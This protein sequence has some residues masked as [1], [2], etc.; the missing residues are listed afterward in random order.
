MSPCKGSRGPG[1]SGGGDL[2]ARQHSYHM[3]IQGP[4]AAHEP[5][6]PTAV[7]PTPNWSQSR[8]SLKAEGVPSAPKPS[9][10]P[11]LRKQPGKS[12]HRLKVSH[13]DQT[14][15]E[16]EPRGQRILVPTVQAGPP[17]PTLGNGAPSS[18]LPDTAG[19]TGELWQEE[20]RHGAVEI[21]TAS[22]SKTPW[23][24]QWLHDLLEHTLSSQGA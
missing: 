20:S 23:G 22:E 11:S 7:E 8:P 3:G 9:L 16:W 17:A 5:S 19:N 4:W 10:E 21:R 15:G 6:R 14:T 2:P 1:D 18:Q 13:A 24:A 12:C